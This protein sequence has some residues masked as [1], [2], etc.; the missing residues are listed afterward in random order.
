MG[1]LGKLQSDAKI[2]LKNQ[3]IPQ[4]HDALNR[5]KLVCQLD[6]IGITTRF[7]KIAPK[8]LEG[9]PAPWFP[10]PGTRNGMARLLPGKADGRGRAKETSHSFPQQPISPKMFY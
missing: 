10:V 8:A 5:G 2:L 4:S 6:H 1:R 9:F 7:I 3:Q